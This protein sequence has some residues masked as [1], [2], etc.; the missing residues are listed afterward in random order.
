MRGR[1]SAGGKE[2]EEEMKKKMKVKDRK[3]AS[4]PF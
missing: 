2:G 4:F 1:G 3:A